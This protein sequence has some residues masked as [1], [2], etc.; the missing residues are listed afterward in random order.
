MIISRHTLLCFHFWYPYWF[1]GLVIS[2]SVLQMKKL[3]FRKFCLIAQG[4][5][6]SQCWKH[7]WKLL[8]FCLFVCY[9]PLTPPPPVLVFLRHWVPTNLQRL[10]ADLPRFTPF[11]D[12]PCYLTAFFSSLI[13]LCCPLHMLCNLVIVFPNCSVPLLCFS[14]IIVHCA[15]FS[16]L[17][18][19]IF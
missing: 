4:Q 18:L 5:T 19:D 6:A 15:S 13:L 10:N 14:V 8:F 2:G 7:C 1:I 16:Q 11:S 9:P 12:S 3:K 17:S